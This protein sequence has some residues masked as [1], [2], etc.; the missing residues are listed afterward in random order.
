MYSPEMRQSAS[1]EIKMRRGTRG[2]HRGKRRIWGAGAWY[3]CHFVRFAALLCEKGVRFGDHRVA[4]AAGRFGQ[5]I[6]GD[7]TAR[8]RGVMF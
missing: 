7:R 1:A 8:N 3:I 4:V 2:A 5:Q 6:P